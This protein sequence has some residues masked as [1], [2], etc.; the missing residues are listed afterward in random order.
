MTGSIRQEIIDLLRGGPLSAKEISRALRVREREVYEHLGH[1]RLSLA[2]A[3]GE[4]LEVEPSRCLGCGYVFRKRHRLT[5]PSR[6]PICR[7]S[8][9]SEPRYQ[10]ASRHGATH[11]D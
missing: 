6:C 9:I 8:H 1:V 11:G 4:R 10:V 2:A 5:A 3:K 7:G